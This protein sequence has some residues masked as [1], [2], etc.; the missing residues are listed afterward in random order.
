[1]NVDPD[2]FN[3]GRWSAIIGRILALESDAEGN[4]PTVGQFPQMSMEPHLSMYRQLAQNF[5]SATDLPQ[6]S[7]GI[8]ADN[9]ASSEAMQ[10]AEAQL[11]DEAEYQWGIFDP[12]LIRIAQNVAMLRDDLTEPPEESWKLGV[13]HK[14]ARY[15]SPQAAADFT[16]K[17]VSAI[18]KIG[19]TTEGLRGLGYSPEAIDSMEAE[20]RRNG[21]SS[22]LGQLIQARTVQPT[23]ATPQAP[24]EAQ[25]A[26]ED[27][28]TLKSKFDALGV[29]IRSGVDPDNAAEKLGLTGIKFTGGVPVSLRMPEGDAQ[30]LEER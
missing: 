5:C 17:A 21:S 22:V 29:A 24:S 16:V 12:S 9:P 15:V 1:M 13:K 7:V 28:A 26:Q 27:A 20:W 19:E 3:A 4:S 2:S 10:A 11:S 6:S 8:F 18:P 30:K 14:P 23:S 25:T